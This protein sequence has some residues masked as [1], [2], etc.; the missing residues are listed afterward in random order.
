MMPNPTYLNFDLSIEVGRIGYRSRVIR[1]EMG[2]ASV[3]FSLPFAT[4][5]L[6][7]V[8]WLAQRLSRHLHLKE[9]SEPAQAALDPQ[10]LGERLYNAVF[11]GNVGISLLR[12]LD[13]A[14]RQGVGLR[15]RLRLDNTTP[16]LAALPWEYLYAPPLNRFLVLSDQTVLVRYIEFDQPPQPL[17][18]TGALKLLGIVSNPHDVPTLNVEQEWQRLQRALAPLLEQGGLTLERLPTATLP[19]LQNRLRQGDVH[20]IHYIGHGYFDTATNT[21][22]LVLED[23]NGQH[24]LVTAKD[25]GVY[26]HGHA[27]LRLLFLNACEGARS[28]R[29]D[30]FAGLAQSLVRQ[31]IPAVVAMQFEVSDTA[32]ITL[33]QEFYQALA[34]GYPVDAALAEARKAV[35][36]AGNPY[37]W[38]T[39]V[40]FS[41]SADN[42][43][44]ALPQKIVA[45]IIE[46]KPF[47]PETIPIPAGPFLMGSDNDAKNEQ[48][49]HEVFL[50]DYGI[51]KVPVT[52]QEYAKFLKSG[53]PEAKGR[54]AP[55]KLGWW[56]NNDPPE[57]KE[58]HPVVG[59]SWEDASA[60]CD[61]LRR[62]TGRHYRLP[63]EAEWEKAARG[64]DGRR[65]PWGNDWQEG[66]CNVA[67]KGTT[68]VD[69]YEEGISPYACYDMLGN[70]EEWCNTIWGRDEHNNDYPYPYRIDRREDEPAKANRPD[71]QRI[72][73]GGSFYDQ[74][75]EVRSSARN[76]SGP[77][78]K[79]SY[80]GFRV[81]IQPTQ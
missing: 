57:G 31:S 28:G 10:Q 9:A 30:A 22:G 49:Q 71:V 7:A 67:G 43:L 70:V 4:A 35:L 36:G 73:R 45:P 37:E 60:Y 5:E 38:G 59:V 27:A 17:A 3:E 20:L 44:L 75:N 6:R 63:S 81:A 56:A 42:R 14:R 2:E 65:Y 41:R 64:S 48:P 78:N 62:E 53:A 52:N 46:R 68:A 11:A 76:A 40:L 8:P 33:A 12:N 23:E 29:E 55:K 69:V 72:Y 61:W 47:E 21:G 13:E 54:E 15:I 77:S 24:R 39:P 1:S 51:G 58:K 26:L 25:L 34:D 16:E 74:A 79:V 50:P 18:V 32:A 80:R 19:A 66:H